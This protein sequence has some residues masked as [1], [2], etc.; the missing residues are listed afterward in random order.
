MNVGMLWFD[1]DRKSDLPAKVKRAATY[2]QGKYGVHPNLCF[3]HPSMAAKKGSESSAE[4]SIK[5]G[6]I[7]VRLTKTVLPH[8]FWIGIHHQE[9]DPAT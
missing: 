8:H 1:N 9:S 3:V 6:D 4:K 2:Y 5:S 7:E